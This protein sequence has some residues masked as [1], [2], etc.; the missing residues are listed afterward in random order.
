MS[1][2]PTLPSLALTSQFVGTGGCPSD[3]V[4]AVDFPQSYERH[5]LLVLMEDSRVSQHGFDSTQ[6][7][8]SVGTMLVVAMDD[9]RPASDLVEQRQ[10]GGNS[11][12]SSSFAMDDVVILEEDY[13]IDRSG[14]I[15]SIKFSNCVHGQID[16][17]MRKY[18]NSSF[19]GRSIG[20]KTLHARLLSKLTGDI[21][22]IDLENGYFLMTV[23][24]RRRRSAS[25]YANNKSD[26]ARFHNRIDNGSRSSTLT[27][28]EDE[29]VGDKRVS[30]A[31]VNSAEGNGTNATV[32]TGSMDVSR[33]PKTTKSAA[34][35][36]SNPP[37]K[38]KGVVQRVDRLTKLVSARML[39]LSPRITLPQLSLL[40]WMESFSQQLADPVP[41]EKHL[42]DGDASLASLGVGTDASDERGINDVTVTVSPSIHA[43]LVDSHVTMDLELALAALQFYENRFQRSIDPEVLFELRG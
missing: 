31:G 40:D 35:L 15:P 30:T 9:S 6:G 14:K 17:N 12:G 26:A 41:G 22:L 25:T 19:V 8:K 21:Q 3:T 11:G 38:S 34:Y 42:P 7:D 4:P 2:T 29:T 39:F 16:N 32:N 13:V 43:S 18:D 24:T 5:G 27:V 1:E 23:D 10:G 37:K 20:F 28:D 33:Q 36:K